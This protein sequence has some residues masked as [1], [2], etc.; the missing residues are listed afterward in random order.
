[1]RISYVITMDSITVQFPDG[2]LTVTEDHASFED[3]WDILTDLHRGPVQAQDTVDALWALMSPT[4]RLQEWS[5]GGFEIK[6]GTISFR[7]ENLPEEATHLLLPLFEEGN[8]GW[9]AFA[10]FWARLMRNPSFRATQ[11]LLGW[12]R[13]HH[14]SLDME[15]YLYFYKGV[16]PDYTDSFSGTFSSAP[17]EH[18]FMER[19]KVSDDSNNA[20]DHGFHVGTLGFAR[21]YG[22]VVIVRVDPADVV[23]VPTATA[24]KLGV[25]Q[26]WSVG[27]ATDVELP[28]EIWQPGNGKFCTGYVPA[29]TVLS[30]YSVEL[31]TAA[32]AD[33]RIMADVLHQTYGYSPEVC[34]AMLRHTP[35][36]LAS[37]LDATAAK[38]L[39]DKLLGRKNGLDLAGSSDLT[40]PAGTV[41]KLHGK[42]SAAIDPLEALGTLETPKKLQ[43]RKDEQRAAK[44]RPSEESDLRE[45]VQAN[46][47][48]Q[49]ALHATTESP[50]EGAHEKKQ[51]NRPQ[52]PASDASEEDYV[53][54]MPRAELRKE[55]GKLHISGTSKLSGGHLRRLLIAV[56]VHGVDPEVFRSIKAANIKERLPLLRKK[57]GEYASR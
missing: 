53:N 1:M 28:G 51:T 7:G 14:I 42:S 12:V 16:R 18:N 36:T 13:T 37:G 34:K 21:A 50:K 15:G 2:P 19:N 10:N 31:V 26:Y 3:I 32:Q 38:G 23:R 8:S 46:L 25:S 56:R 43:K 49:A 30:E 57:I 33:T 48:K 17:G 55:A 24:G 41:L 6:N 40:S 5:G 45:R 27:D 20:C 39:V 35:T 9:V 11:E 54:G 22:R 47:L 44:R 29:E 52:E 4:A